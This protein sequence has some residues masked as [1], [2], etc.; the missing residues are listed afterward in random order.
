MRPDETR[1]AERACE[2]TASDQNCWTRGCR[3]CKT[4]LFR[5]RVQMKALKTEGTAVGL[6]P[7]F[8][9]EEIGVLLACA[10][11]DKKTGGMFL[12]TTQNGESVCFQFQGSLLLSARAVAPLCAE[13]AISFH[14]FP[15]V[16]S[17][18]RQDTLSQDTLVQYSLF[19]ARTAQLMRMAQE[20]HCH[21]CV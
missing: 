18:C 7:W 20:L 9:F 12:R 6:I 15:V 11:V 19:T 10:D 1:K 14:Q 3:S 5:T 13:C 21:L 8:V 16:S 17:V 4:E 2:N